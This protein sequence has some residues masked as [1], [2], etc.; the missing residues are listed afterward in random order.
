MIPTFIEALKKYTKDYSDPKIRFLLLYYIL[1]QIEDDSMELIGESSEQAIAETKMLIGLHAKDI[2]SIANEEALIEKLDELISRLYPDI[3]N[4]DNISENSSQSTDFLSKEGYLENYAKILKIKKEVLSRRLKIFLFVKY[5][6]YP[7][8]F[9]TSLASWVF[10]IESFDNYYKNI[11]IKNFSQH[12]T[13]ELIV[14]FLGISSLCFA[15]ALPFFMGEWL[16]KKLRSWIFKIN[17]KI[18]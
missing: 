10:L 1:K 16:E 12:W 15:I 13:F 9:F 3:K 7:T 6:T 11:L 8:F 14:F 2:F 17:K 5:I 18:K 4:K